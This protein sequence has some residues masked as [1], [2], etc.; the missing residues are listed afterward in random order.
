MPYASSKKK[1]ANHLGR[2]ATRKHGIAADLLSKQASTFRA[3]EINVVTPSIVCLCPAK[4]V[5]KR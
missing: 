5:Q 2:N 1:Y 4:S 3:V